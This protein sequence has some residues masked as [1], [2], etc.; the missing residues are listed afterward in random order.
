MSR[1]TLLMAALAVALIWMQISKDDSVQSTTLSGQLGDHASVAFRGIVNDITGKQP[2]R[3]EIDPDHRDLSLW[4][5]PTINWSREAELAAR[6]SESFG[7]T[8]LRPRVLVELSPYCAGC[9]TLRP[10]FYQ[11][12]VFTQQDAYDFVMRSLPADDAATAHAPVPL[13][14]LLVVDR[15]SGRETVIATASD[16]LTTGEL[17]DRLKSKMAALTNG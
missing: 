1:K 16:N 5:A 10:V 7:P 4:N 3:S 9:E 11:V 2:V 12:G 17:T 15:K 13:W 14:R 8:L 6:G